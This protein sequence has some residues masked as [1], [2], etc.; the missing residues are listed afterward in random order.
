MYGYRVVGVVSMWSF[1]IHIHSTHTQ[2]AILSHSVSVHTFPSLSLDAATLLRSKAVMVESSADELAV[3]FGFV[4]ATH[5]LGGRHKMN[6]VVS[7][8]SLNRSISQYGSLL[9]LNAAN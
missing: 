7:H 3:C 4:S 1:A 5:N 8:L 9:G 6:E 2:C